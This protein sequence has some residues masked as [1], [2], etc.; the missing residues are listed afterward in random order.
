MTVEDAT[1][2]QDVEGGN[3]VAP[4]TATP[5]LKGSGSRGPGPVQQ[6]ILAALYDPA[7]ILVLTTTE[8]AGM[9]L[10]RADREAIR[11]V[12]R[13]VDALA[14]RGLVDT[15]TGSAWHQCLR[16]PAGRPLYRTYWRRARC[17][18]YRYEVTQ[19]KARMRWVCR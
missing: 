1:S 14:A 16:P 15:W 6:S 12:R 9:V 4:L 13:A 7:A 17:G 3:E 2:P 11:Q 19:A 8:L 18:S 10:G 5:P